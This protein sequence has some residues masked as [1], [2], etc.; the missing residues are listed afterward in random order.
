MKI[1]EENHD[2]LLEAFKENSFLA[3]DYKEAEIKELHKTL[4]ENIRTPQKIWWFNAS[5]PMDFMTDEEAVDFLLDFL[6]GGLP[7]IRERQE[8]YH[9]HINKGGF[10]NNVFLPIFFM[11]KHKNGWM[12]CSSTVETIP[13]RLIFDMCLFQ[14]ELDVMLESLKTSDDVLKTIELPYFDVEGNG[15]LI[16]ETVVPLIVMNSSM[17][18]FQRISK[19]PEAALEIVDAIKG[20]AKPILKEDGKVVLSVSVT[21]EENL[22]LLSKITDGKL[23]HSIGEVMD[24]DGDYT[25]ELVRGYLIVVNTQP[26]LKK[27]N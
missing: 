3:I 15:K 21:S 23:I 20:M 5:V 25:F 4:P 7:E 9:P 10:I 6:E 24:A 27:V 16:K 19:S 14:N 2:L 17:K 22:E 13:S 26:N 18:E 12:V 1:S 11:Y 8:E